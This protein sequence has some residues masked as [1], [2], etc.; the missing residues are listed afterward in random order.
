M[1]DILLQKDVQLCVVGKVF[2]PNRLKVLALNKTLDEY[3]RLVEWY[4]SFNSERV[5]SMRTV[6]RRLK[7]SSNLT[8]P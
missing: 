3:F 5:S 7:N 8:P 1:G 4:L 2:K 6:M